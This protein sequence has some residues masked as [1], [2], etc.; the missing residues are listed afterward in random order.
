MVSWQDHARE[1]AAGVFQPL[2]PFPDP[3]V[4]EQLFE[5]P[6]NDRR[7]QYGNAQRDETFHTRAPMEDPQP[8]GSHTGHGGLSLQGDRHAAFPQTLG[9]GELVQ[10]EG[11][12][13]S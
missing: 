13:P 5:N 4:P 7:N 1:S 9:A 6:N 11:V 3:D 12:E 10:S 8:E 2:L